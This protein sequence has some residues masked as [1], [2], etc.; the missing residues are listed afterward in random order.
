MTKKSTEIPL[1]LF[2]KA[3]IAGKVKT[4]LT[5]DCSYQQAAE[6]A[7]IILEESLAK[8]V[9]HW[10][11]K[12]FLSVWHFNQHPFIVSMLERY[13]VELLQQTEGDLGEKMQSTF[14]Q[15]GYP[16]AIMGCDAPMVTSRTFSEAY[17][18]LQ[19]GRHVIGPSEDGGYYLIGVSEPAP[20]LFADVAWGTDAVLAKTLKL[21]SQDDIELI[22]LPES[23]DIDRWQ[24]VKKASTH[25]TAL[26]K[27]L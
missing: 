19:D 21:A 18:A 22:K 7:K 4:R 24:D 14:E 2:A 23:Y 9:Q 8:A 15:V 17:I 5:S 3:P 16:A 25:I 13:A 10:P 6:I 20:A 1:V 27:F 12:V 26:Q 11:G